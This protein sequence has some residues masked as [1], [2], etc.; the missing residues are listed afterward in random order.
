MSATETGPI[1][2][3]FLKVGMLA[4]ALGARSIKDFSGCWQH[5]FTHDG[6]LWQIALNAHLEPNEASPIGAMACQV[7]RLSVAVWFNGWLAAIFDPRGGT[8]V[9]GT[10]ANEDAFIEAL[11]AEMARVQ[12]K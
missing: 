3:A 4:H 2:E 10:L 1:C 9:A 12:K 6:S 5:Q 7:P 8:F 11:D